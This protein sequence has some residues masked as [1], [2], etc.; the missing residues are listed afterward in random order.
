MIFYWD[1]VRTVFKDIQIFIV[2]DARIKPYSICPNPTA[3]VVTKI[4]PLEISHAA[5][6]FGLFSLRVVN[7]DPRIYI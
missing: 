7:G 3:S 1:T 2:W 6:S 5:L 4:A